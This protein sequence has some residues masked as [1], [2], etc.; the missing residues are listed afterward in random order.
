MDIYFG[1]NLKK[2]R[3]EQ[4][5]TQEALADFLGVTFQAVSKWERG[6]GYPDIATL[7]II[8][9]FFGVSLDDLLGV[10]KVQRE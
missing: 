5:L 6:D 8:S 7:P 10:D 4:N 1:E 2:L 3:K 9:S